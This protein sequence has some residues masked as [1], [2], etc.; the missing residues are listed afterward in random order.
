MT[1]LI[2]VVGRNLSVVYIYKCSLDWGGG[3]D[4]IGAALKHPWI[5]LKRCCASHGLN[6]CSAMGYN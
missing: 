1:Y 6:W 2:G 4:Y 3:K 5:Q